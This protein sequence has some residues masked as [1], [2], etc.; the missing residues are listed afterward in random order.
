MLA[1]RLSPLEAATK[2]LKLY[3][4]LRI[5]QDWGAPGFGEQQAE[6]RVQL[7]MEK[8]T[9]LPEKRASKAEAP[10]YSQGEVRAPRD[11]PEVP[12][13]KKKAMQGVFCF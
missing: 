12:Q 8:K 6:K 2:D 7:L 1:P 11:E 13:S 9:Q 5:I 10:H 3:Q 4:A